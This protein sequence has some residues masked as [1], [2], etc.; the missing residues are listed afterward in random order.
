MLPLSLN[1]STPAKQNHSSMVVFNGEVMLGT[2]IVHV[3]S[4]L[5]RQQQLSNKENNFEND[6]I[7][8]SHRYKPVLGGELAGERYMLEK[9]LPIQHIKLIW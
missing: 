4:L 1:S 5:E 7:V 6:Y 3:K 2:I 9:Y 8:R